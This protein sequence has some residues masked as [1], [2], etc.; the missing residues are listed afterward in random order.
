MYINK[1][2]GVLL[3]SLI[4]IKDY[5]LLILRYIIIIVIRLIV[6]KSLNISFLK[7]LLIL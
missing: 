3:N 1:I 6:Y 7:L 5:K 4:N 2:A